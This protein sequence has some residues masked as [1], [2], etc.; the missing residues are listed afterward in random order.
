V[1]WGA[2]H[3]TYVQA[4][5]ELGF[6]GLLLLLGMIATAFMSLQRAARRA[7][8]ASPGGSE[9]SRLAQSL[10]A[11][12]VGFAV[13]AFFLSLAYADMLYMLIA[14]TIALAKCARADTAPVPASSRLR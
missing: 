7:L 5:A 6:P 13:G 1:W 2:A 8:R 10:M 14:L 11:A 3:N 4:G 9:V 12:I